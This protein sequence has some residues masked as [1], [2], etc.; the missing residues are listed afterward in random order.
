MSKKKRIDKLKPWTIR[1]PEEVLDWL[2]VKEATETIERN[3]HVSMNTV[4]VDILR[5]A[6]TADKK[7]SG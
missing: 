6:M 3:S 1:M 5:R 4:A 7:K 2:R